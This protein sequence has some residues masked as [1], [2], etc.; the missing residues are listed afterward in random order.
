M[1]LIAVFLFFAYLSSPVLWSCVR[2]F[3]YYE[4]APF[5]YL[6]THWCFLIFQ[7]FMSECYRWIYCV[8]IRSVLFLFLFF[9]L[10]SLLIKNRVLAGS[11]SKY[12]SCLLLAWVCSDADYAHYWAIMPIKGNPGYLENCQ[13]KLWAKI[14]GAMP[15]VWRKEVGHIAD[16][17]LACP[18]GQAA[19]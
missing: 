10:F 3:Q 4:L 16:C 14:F 5:R 6:G 19:T 1:I 12:Y 7:C 13:L 9:L 18:Y 17:F 8:C 15:L 11:E 2:I